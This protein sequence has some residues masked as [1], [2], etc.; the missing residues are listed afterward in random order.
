MI[1]NIAEHTNDFIRSVQDQFSDRSHCRETRL[2][3]VRAFIGVLFISGTL[4]VNHTNHLDLWSDS[5]IG[6]ELV[7]SVMSYQRFLF[8]CRCL[9]FDD[10]ATRAARRE[11]TNSRL[12]VNCLM[13]SSSTANRVILPAN[14][15]PSTNRFFLFVDVVLFGCILVLQSPRATA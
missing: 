13:P 12:F 7:R 4:R 1:A 15:L 14:T 6:S 9:R 2:S 11:M 3:E 8:L 5:G 10:R